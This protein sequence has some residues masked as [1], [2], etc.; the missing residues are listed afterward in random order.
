MP[1]VTEL[2]AITLSVEL[3]LPLVI[4]VGLKPALTPAGIPPT[5][6]ATVL[7]KPTDPPTVVV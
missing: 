5:V 1:G 2:D 6:K 7:V 3:P 4:E